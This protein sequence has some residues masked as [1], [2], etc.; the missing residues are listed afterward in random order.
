MLLQ[1][2]IPMHR[3]SAGSIVRRRPLNRNVSPARC[4]PTL[5]RPGTPRARTRP[6]AWEGSAR[7]GTTFRPWVSA[8]R[9]RRSYAS[10]GRLHGAVNQGT[11]PSI[12]ARSIRILP[13]NED[14]GSR[15]PV[16]CWGAQ[17]KTE[18]SSWLRPGGSLERDVSR[19]TSGPAGYAHTADQVQTLQ[20]LRC[21][22][23]TV[24]ARRPC[25]PGNEST[26]FSQQDSH[27]S[28][29]SLGVCHGEQRAFFF[30]LLAHR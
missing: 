21:C 27:V 3:R 4:G 14:N 6:P 28:H 10:H 16:T 20:I 22:L 18:L 1:S 15:G 13:P 2:T 19:E 23:S 26:E 5:C 12:Q 11:R 17:A 29:R 7:Q 9:V 8:A 24:D 25:H 30:S